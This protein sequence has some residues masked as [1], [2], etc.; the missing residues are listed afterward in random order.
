MTK[1]NHVNYLNYFFIT[2]VLI[3]TDIFYAV[4]LC[5]IDIHIQITMHLIF[6]NT[7]I[8]ALFRAN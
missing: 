4:M 7:P 3:N 8:H 6:S 2:F 1:T 5:F